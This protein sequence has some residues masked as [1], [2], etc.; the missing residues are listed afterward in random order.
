VK[1][2]TRRLPLTADLFVPAFARPSRLPGQPVIRITNHCNGS[3]PQYGV[4]REAKISC[5]KLPAETVKK[6]LR[7]CAENGAEAVSFT[8]G[9]P[10]INFPEIMGLPDY[11]GKLKIPADL[12]PLS[13]LYALSHEN[14]RDLLFP[15]LGGIC[16]LFSERKPPK[17]GGKS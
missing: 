10:F 2:N 17:K 1:K 4:R 14:S 7:D 3:C 16:D 5:V 12:H 13:A 6:A 11:A 9:E 15:C 8:G